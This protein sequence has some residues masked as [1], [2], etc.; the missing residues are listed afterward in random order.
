MITQEELKQRVSYNKETGKFTR[1]ASKRGDAANKETGT[2]TNNGYVLLWVAG[3]LQKAHRMAWLYEYGELPDCDIDHINGIKSD[4]RI[5][6]LRPATRSENNQNRRMSNKNNKHCTI[7]VSRN[8]I[9]KYV[10]GI[11]INR[12]AIHLGCF[13]TIEEASDAYQRAK[14]EHHPFA[15]TMVISR[16]QPF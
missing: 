4:N 1:L 2:L 11:T 13:E 14:A 7:G 8:R 6:N 10:A 12:K 15:P 3:N 9:G 16:K 5:D